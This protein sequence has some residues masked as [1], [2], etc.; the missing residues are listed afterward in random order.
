MPILN[1]STSVPTMRSIS[2]IQHKLVKAGAFQVL[3][4]YEA[5]GR[6]ASVSFKIQTKFGPIAYRMPANVPAIQAVLR[7]QFPR[8]SQMQ[9]KAEQ[10]AWRILKDWLEAQLA[11][12]ETGMVAVE[13]VFLPYAQDATG[14]TVYEALLE[15]K[16]GGIAL[17]DR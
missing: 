2:E 8:S 5:S 16:F 14:R 3:H 11:L 13:Q 9:Q 12:V 1:Y 4:E 15:K 10:V 6:V 17:E 7:K